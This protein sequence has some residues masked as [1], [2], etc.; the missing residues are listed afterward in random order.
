MATHDD[1]STQQSQQPPQ[2]PPQQPRASIPPILGLRPTTPAEQARLRA[3]AERGR[4]AEAEAE[5][6]AQSLPHEPEKPVIEPDADEHNANW[7]RLLAQR[8]RPQQNKDNKD[9]ET[10]DHG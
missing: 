7:L 3:L 1:E 8:K 2:Q 10:P 9:K 5:N 6:A 4:R